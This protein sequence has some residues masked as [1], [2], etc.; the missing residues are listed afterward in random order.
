MVVDAHGQIMASRT[1]D[2]LSVILM[3]TRLKLYFGMLSLPVNDREEISSPGK[4]K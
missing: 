2:A 3:A 1:T 4:M